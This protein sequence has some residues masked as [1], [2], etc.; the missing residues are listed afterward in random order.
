LQS[1][2]R[3]LHQ[4]EQTD[5]TSTNGCANAQKSVELLIQDG[6]NYLSRQ[7]ANLEANGQL[8]SAVKDAREVFDDVS[9]VHESLSVY[10]KEGGPTDRLQV[11]F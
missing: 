6:V 5:K 10:W 4:E 7:L 8:R 3:I 11:P 2:L 9:I 1:V